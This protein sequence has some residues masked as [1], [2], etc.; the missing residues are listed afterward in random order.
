MDAKRF[1]HIA[2][3]LSADGFTC[4]IEARCRPNG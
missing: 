2:K 3:S 1:D 4:D